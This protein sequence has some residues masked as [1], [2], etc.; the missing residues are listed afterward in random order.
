MQLDKTNTSNLPPST[1]YLTG[2]TFDQITKEGQII[3]PDPDN[4]Q[5]NRKVLF[6]D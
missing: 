1:V 2:Q 3:S 4:A 5:L 6:D